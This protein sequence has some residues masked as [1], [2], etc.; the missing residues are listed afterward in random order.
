MRL[1]NSKTTRRISCFY[2]VNQ[3]VRQVVTPVMTAQIVSFHYELAYKGNKAQHLVML[4]QNNL[5]YFIG[6]IFTLSLK[7]SFCYCNT[8]TYKGNVVFITKLL[9]LIHTCLIG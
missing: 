8:I 3:C 2:K 4:W 7:L 6:V 5:C 1:K 9:V